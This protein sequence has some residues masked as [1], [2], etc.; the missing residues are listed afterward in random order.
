MPAKFTRILIGWTLACAPAFAQGII[1]TMAGTG[2][3]G[4]S[5]DGGPAISAAI[6]GAIGIARDSLGHLYFADRTNLRIR[7]IAPNGTITTIAGNG[8]YGSTGDGGP[9][10]NAT[11]GWVT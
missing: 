3:G 10:L 6:C 2:M 7:M 4:F 1:T 5:G 11:L 9:S 8:N